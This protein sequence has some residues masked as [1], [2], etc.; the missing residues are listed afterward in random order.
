VVGAI[1]QVLFGGSFPATEFSPAQGNSFEDA[2]ARKS[3]LK[4]HGFSRA[5]FKAQTT[6]AL[7]AEGYLLE[8]LEPSLRG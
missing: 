8:D 7:A 6:T 2:E 1:Q 4:G 5:G 3:F